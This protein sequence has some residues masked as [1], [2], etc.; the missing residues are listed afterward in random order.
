ME[1]GS[2]KKSRLDQG[3]ILPRS[4]RHVPETDA[5]PTEPHGTVRI[6][7]HDKYTATNTICKLI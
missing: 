5:Q 3:S 2:D 4:A 7:T 6:L 1:N